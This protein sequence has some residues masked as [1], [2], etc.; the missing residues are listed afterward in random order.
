M[1]GPRSAGPDLCHVDDF[2]PHVKALRAH[3]AGGFSLKRICSWCEAFMGLKTC[4]AE[5]HG[6]ISHGICPK[7]LAKQLPAGLAAGVPISTRGAAA[8]TSMP[9]LPTQAPGVDTVENPGARH[10]SHNSAVPR[11]LSM[12]NADAAQFEAAIRALVD[13][14]EEGDWPRAYSLADG[15]TK[16][17]R[18]K[19]LE[20]VADGAGRIKF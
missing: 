4:G 11:A 3:V 14:Y 19:C 9:P 17:M 15:L 16:F 10:I 12:A 7:C 13:M 18:R 1:R 2:A 20:A 5:Q 8:T 6:Q